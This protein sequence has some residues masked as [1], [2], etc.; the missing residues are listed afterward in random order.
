MAALRGDEL[1]DD[2]MMPD[3]DDEVVV[4][5]GRAVSGGVVAA[6]RRGPWY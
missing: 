4:A 3:G 6:P 1:E 2:N 5:R